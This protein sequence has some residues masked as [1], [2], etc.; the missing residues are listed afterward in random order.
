MSFIPYLFFDDT[1]EEAL[2]FYAEVFGGKVEGVMRYAELPP[3]AGEVPKGRE[4][5]VMNAT[6]QVGEA[7]LMASDSMEGGAGRPSGI[8]LYKGF[9]DVERARRVFDR[10]AKDGE[11]TMPFEPTFWSKGFGRCRDRYGTDWMIGVDAPE[12]HA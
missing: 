8:S 4:T 2:N 7:S 12:D 10:L 9:D 1:C 5:L 11:V 3:D 6:L